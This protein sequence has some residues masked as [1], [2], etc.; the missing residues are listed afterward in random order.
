MKQPSKFSLGTVESAGVSCRY[1]CFV[2]GEF[3]F[4]YSISVPVLVCQY[5]PDLKKILCTE[6]SFAP[7]EVTGCRE[8]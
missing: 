3:T 4:V 6:A 1:K 8:K 2:S 7:G 5:Y